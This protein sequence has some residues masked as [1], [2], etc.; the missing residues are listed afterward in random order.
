MPIL[1]PVG[2]SPRT[3]KEIISDM[4]D[5]L[6]RRREREISR[7]RFVRLYGGLRNE[8]ETTVEYAKFH[9]AVCF[10]SGGICERCYST[11]ATQV[12]HKVPV[13][14]APHL[15]LDANFAEHVCLDCHKSTDLNHARWL[16]G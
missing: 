16:S 8:L 4:R 5:L 10:R 13:S 15:A 1:I 2:I 7:T 3:A 11:M 14:R 6:Y 9:A 12:H